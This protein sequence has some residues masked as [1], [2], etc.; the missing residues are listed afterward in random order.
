M[1]SSLPLLSVIIPVFNG[2]ATLPAALA[3]VVSQQGARL[4]II[5]VDDGSVDGSADIARCTG[6]EIVCVSQPNQGPAAARNRGLQLAHGD[7]ISFLDADD[8]WPADRVWHHMTLFQENPDAGIVIGATQTVRLIGDASE[9][10]QRA[11]PVLPAPL[12]QHQLGSAT[13]RRE[14]FDRVGL[15]TEALRI[16]EDKE[17]FQRALNAGVAIKMTPTIALYYCLR[18][19]SLTDGTIAH[20][21]GFMGALRSHLQH[22]RA[23][24]PSA[25]P[26]NQKGI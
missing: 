12:I 8:Y 17:W 13:Y 7:Y 10:G 23:A 15:L 25:N 14:I 18:A 2:A 4:E 6:T 22:H 1:V 24:T 26:C 20:H 5:V 3:S 21:V 9:T 19:G 16:G 11:L